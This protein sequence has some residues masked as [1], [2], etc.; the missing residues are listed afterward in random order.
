MTDQ[1]AKHNEE[2]AELLRTASCDPHFLHSDRMSKWYYADCRL[3]APTAESGKGEPESFRLVR[4][5]LDELS[6]VSGATHQPAPVTEAPERVTHDEVRFTVN[7][8]TPMDDTERERFA[9]L[10]RYID[11]QEQSEREVAELRKELEEC[12]FDDCDQHVDVRYCKAHY[13][14]ELRIAREPLLAELGKATSILVN[15]GLSPAGVEDVAAKVALLSN[16]LSESE[17]RLGEAERELQAALAAGARRIG[18]LE[19][20]IADVAD[21]FEQQGKHGLA[22]QLRQFLP[23]EATT[24]VSADPLTCSNCHHPQREHFMGNGCAACDCTSAFPLLPT[25]GEP[26][27]PEQACSGRYGCPCPLHYQRPDDP[28]TP[29]AEVPAGKHAYRVTRRGDS[30]CG[31]VGE[32]RGRDGMLVTLRM[33]GGRGEHIY[34]IS[35]IEPA[36]PAPPRPD[37]D[38]PVMM[39]ELVS[40]LKAASRCKSAGYC[41]WPAGEA[42][43]E[44]AKELKREGSAKL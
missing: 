11:Q 1:R 3:S 43:R 31:L 27:K 22:R 16:K 23:P 14:D 10:Q 2:A 38:R 19:E 12:P 30:L 4:H 7:M 33:E 39:A 25:G 37:G 40:A 42:L 13:E 8:L 6:K 29:A 18:E 41:D 36:D 34:N 17:R 21:G 44:V 5:G 9:A 32:W 35:D 24:S 26:A 20:A 15:M 28:A